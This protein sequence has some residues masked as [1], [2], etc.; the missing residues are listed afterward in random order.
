MAERLLKRRRVVTVGTLDGPA[1]T[2]FGEITD[3][4]VT[5]QGDVLVLDGTEQ[6]VRVF[7]ADGSYRGGFGR[8]GSGPGELRTP[9]A[10]EVLGAG[11]IGIIDRANGVMKLVCVAEADSLGRVV[12]YYG[13]QG[14]VRHAVA[15][16]YTG[17]GMLARNQFSK[18]PIGCSENGVAT[19]LTLFP[20]IQLLSPDGFRQGVSRIEDFEQR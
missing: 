19:G 6:R 14:K 13:T 15:T 4:A 3:I 12:R 1:E 9:I 16:G 17:G 20:I 7:G 8:A 11:Q 10:I 18:G 5:P 2:R